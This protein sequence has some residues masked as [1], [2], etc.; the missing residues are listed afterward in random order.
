VRVLENNKMVEKDVI[1]GLK[2]DG[3]FVEII[4]GLS[5]GETI[6]LKIL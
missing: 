6:I 5:D 2:A 3:G 4:S 1:T